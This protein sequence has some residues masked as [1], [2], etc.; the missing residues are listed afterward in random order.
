MTPNSVAGWDS[1]PYSC[2]LGKGGVFFTL[3]LSFCGCRMLI[4]SGVSGEVDLEK[5]LSN[6]DFSITTDAVGIPSIGGTVS[7]SNA[8]YSVTE[9]GALVLAGTLTIPEPSTATLSL[10]ALAALAMRRRRR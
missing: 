3:D 5:L 9:Q 6:T 7:V 8:S 4:S 10:F 1:C 2:R